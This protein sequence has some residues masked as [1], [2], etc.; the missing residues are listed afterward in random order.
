[1]ECNDCYELLDG[2]VSV[3]QQCENTKQ[4]SGAV[5]KCRR[6]SC[7]GRYTF[8]VCNHVQTLQFPSGF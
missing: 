3:E 5:P 6:K 7:H 2:S 8:T 1:M 4:W